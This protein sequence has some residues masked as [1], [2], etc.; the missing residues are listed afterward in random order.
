H[1]DVTTPIPEGG[2]GEI[3]FVARGLRQNAPARSD[4]GKAIERPAEVEIVRIVGGSHIVRR[5]GP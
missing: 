5:V 2:T 1:A 3:A 4:D